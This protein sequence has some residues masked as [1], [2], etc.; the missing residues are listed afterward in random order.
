MV[1]K[2]NPKPNALTLTFYFLFL[3]VLMLILAS[4][5][6]QPSLCVVS[7]AND[8]N[9]EFI[10][11]PFLLVYVLDLAHKI[12]TNRRQNKAETVAEKMS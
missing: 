5:E 2:P 3:L 6:N 11:I 4:A 8:S 10:Y 1:L 9:K 7:N 12:L